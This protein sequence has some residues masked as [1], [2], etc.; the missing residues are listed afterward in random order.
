MITLNNQLRSQGVQTGIQQ[1]RINPPKRTSRDQ[2][3][4]R[5]NKRN[6]FSTK[7]IWDRCIA[8]ALSRTLSSRKDYFFLTK[9]SSLNSREHVF[10][11]VLAVSG[12]E[13]EERTSSSKISFF[14]S[15]SYS[16]SFRYRSIDDYQSDFLKFLTDVTGT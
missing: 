2:K 13:R 15:L 16:P 7:D 1:L 9:Q 6:A 8:E 14:I 11:R 4:C 3:L 10:F 12:A 5:Y